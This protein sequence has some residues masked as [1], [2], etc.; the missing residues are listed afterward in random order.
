MYLKYIFVF[1]ILYLFTSCK[2]TYHTLLRK[3]T[4]YDGTEFGRITNPK[5]DSVICLP[6]SNNFIFPPI[7][8]IVDSKI[9]RNYKNEID[10]FTKTKT[11]AFI[12]VK[13]DSILYEN[14][15]NG[16]KQSDVNQLFSITKTI[17]S[18]MLGWAMEEGS[19]QSLEQSVK[20]FLPQT[21]GTQLGEVKLKHL[22][23]MSS[24]IN[25]DEYKNILKTLK[26]YYRKEYDNIC[27]NIKVK[28]K[29]GGFFAYKSIDIQILSMCIESATFKNLNEYFFD[30]IWSRLGAKYSSYWS[31]DSKD[32]NIPKYYGGFNASA[33]D[34]VKFGMVYA[35][36][37]SFLGEKLV[38]EWWVNY[39]DDSKNRGLKYN[40]CNAWWADNIKNPQV[41]AFYGAGF[42]GQYLYIDKTKGTVIV[43]LGTGKGGVEWNEVIDNLNKFL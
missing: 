3:P 35:N 7:D 9:F 8:S 6:K 33:I 37:G 19:I 43:R 32:C 5:I 42:G 28:H 17:P 18:A 23:N 13:N 4:I 20:E 11:L 36:R 14:Y 25:V 21:I 24:G 10:F 22:A 16:A 1:F 34:L 40:Y 31:V 15:F 27:E 41:R 38:P 39:C 12:V 29:P 30:K 26:F 2:T